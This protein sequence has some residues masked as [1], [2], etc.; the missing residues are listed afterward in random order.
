MADSKEKVSKKRKKPPAKSPEAREQQLISL[1]ID[2]AEEQLLNGTASSQVILH[3]LKLADSK[4]EL[5][6]EKIRHENEL[7]KVKTANIE[8]Q[9]NIE[10][11]YKDAIDAMKSYS[12]YD[13]GDEDAPNL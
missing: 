4:T 8:S 3:F 12:G 5:E 10:A 11:L 9:K 6:K 7:L 13:T 2:N 1:A